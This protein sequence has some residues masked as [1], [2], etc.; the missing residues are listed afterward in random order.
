[1]F[2]EDKAVQELDGPMAHLVARGAKSLPFHLRRRVGTGD[3]LVRESAAEVRLALGRG[4]RPR[5]KWVVSLRHSENAQFFDKCMVSV[6]AL[7][8]PDGHDI[9]LGEKPDGYG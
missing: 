7:M 9:H 1:M 8:I 3:R 2:A 6:P 4:S 5:R